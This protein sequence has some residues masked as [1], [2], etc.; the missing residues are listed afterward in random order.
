MWG[1]EDPKM[2]NWLKWGGLGYKDDFTI[3]GWKLAGLCYT[4]AIESLSNLWVSCAYWAGEY[5]ILAG[6][7]P[8]F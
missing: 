3:P 5:G 7:Y 4:E 2:E 8:R 1:K 6:K